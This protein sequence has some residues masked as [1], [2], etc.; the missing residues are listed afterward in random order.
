MKMQRN[1]ELATP[2]TDAMIAQ[3]APL[4]VDLD[5]T[6][7]PTDTLVESVLQL[8]KQAPLNLFLLPFWLLRGIA[9]FKA[10]VAGATTFS[11]RSL[12]YRED[13]L[14]FLTE[15]KA[16]GRRLVLATAAHQSIAD[17]VATHIGLFDLVIAS[18]ANCN[19]KGERK[20]AAIR[21][22]VGNE[23]V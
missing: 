4:V 11:A 9:Y 13:L 7:T 22:Q 14:R 20:L 19:L 16:D 1:S 6:L 18:D 15:Q 5:G 2:D 3:A 17:A 10:K 8:I 23:I 12:P 21:E